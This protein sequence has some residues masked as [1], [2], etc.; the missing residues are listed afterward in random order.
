MASNVDPNVVAQVKEFFSNQLTN[1]SKG[2]QL[3]I[4]CATGYLTGCMVD[5]V[6]RAAATAI[7][8]G[9]LLLNLGTCNG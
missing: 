8:G 2:V 9:I 7:G 6:G 1:Q 4:G 5:K 3:G